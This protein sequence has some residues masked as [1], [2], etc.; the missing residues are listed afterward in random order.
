M[1]AALIAEG[2]P[3]M[4]LMTSWKDMAPE[5]DMET[6]MPTPMPFFFLLLDDNFRFLV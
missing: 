2:T 4:G 3:E 5:P 1:A 6:P